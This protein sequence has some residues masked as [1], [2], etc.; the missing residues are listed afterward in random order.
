M[1]LSIFSNESLNVKKDL[2]FRKLISSLFHSTITQ[3]K[4]EYLNSAVV[5]FNIIYVASVGS[6]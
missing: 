1:G 3:G 4:N 6:M 5:D 2:A